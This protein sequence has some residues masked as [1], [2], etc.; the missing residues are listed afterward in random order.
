V[1]LGIAC[2][3]ALIYA[4]LNYTK[5]YQEGFLEDAIGKVCMYF[6]WKLALGGL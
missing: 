4:G 2:L 1:L 6:K 3:A 5:G